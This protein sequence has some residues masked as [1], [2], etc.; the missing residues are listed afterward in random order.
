MWKAF[1]VSV[2]LYYMK[3]MV[4]SQ[5]MWE[6]MHIEKIVYLFFGSTSAHREMGVWLQEN[7]AQRSTAN[8]FHLSCSLPPSV[9]LSND[10][11]QNIVIQN[12]YS[13]LP[14]EYTILF[15]CVKIVAIEEFVLFCS[16]CFTICCF[17]VI[18]SHYQ[19]IAS[20]GPLGE[21]LCE[22]LLHFKRQMTS[23]ALKFMS[24]TE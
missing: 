18:L 13:H 9:F 8:T 19:N 15:P 17:T 23:F 10:F 7:V 5:N 11:K 4:L 12:K 22:F 14:Q 2:L 21:N 24:L 6:K 3:R 1:C 16:T 20:F